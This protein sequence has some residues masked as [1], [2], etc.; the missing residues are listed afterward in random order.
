MSVQKVNKFPY[1]ETRVY[2]GGVIREFSKDVDS[3]ELVW[4]RDRNRRLVSVLNGEGWKIQMD[5]E[6]PIDLTVGMKIRIKENTYHRLFRGSTNLI[7]NIH[8]EL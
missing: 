6:L 4:H 1:K 7:V 5:N 8:E 3:E 2:D